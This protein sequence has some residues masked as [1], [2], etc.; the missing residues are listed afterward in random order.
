MHLVKFISGTC[1]TTK[2]LKLS[3][4][5]GILSRKH[6]RAGP[7]LT[8]GGHFEL[9]RRV[10]DKVARSGVTDHCGHKRATELSIVDCQIQFV[11]AYIKELPTHILFEKY[12]SI[13]LQMTNCVKNITKQ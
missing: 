9:S 13:I 11:R 6:L 10:I 3:E 1:Q 8:N 4:R 2:G 12:F 7:G 5:N